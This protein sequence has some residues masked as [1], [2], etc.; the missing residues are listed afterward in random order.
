MKEERLEQY[1]KEFELTCKEDAEESAQAAFFVSKIFDY[2]RSQELKKHF[3]N[4]IPKDSK[5]QKPYYLIPILLA[6]I[7]IF[8]FAL[9]VE[10]SKSGDYL[11]DLKSASHN[12]FENVK[13]SANSSNNL[14]SKEDKAS[15][16]LPTIVTD[17]QDQAKKAKLEKTTN[18]TVPT[19]KEEEVKSVNNAGS[20]EVETTPNSGDVLEDVK[21]EIQKKIENV[22]LPP[23]VEDGIP[24][25]QLPKP[26]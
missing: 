19:Y 5:Q 26:F 14:N 17:K 2:E 1:L 9:T 7:A 4:Q 12:F 13:K 11:Y 8:G 23:A 20:K 18:S 21:D 24:S 25:S 6:L 15:I 16:V 22:Q 10:A 3:L